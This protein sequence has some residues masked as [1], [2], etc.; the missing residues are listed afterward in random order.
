MMGKVLALSP[1]KINE[2]YRVWPAD[3]DEEQFGTLVLQD[4]KKLSCSK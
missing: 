1:F 2:H 3:C 4:S